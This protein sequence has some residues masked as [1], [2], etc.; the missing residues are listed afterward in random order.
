MGSM[1]IQA[2]VPL[3]DPP[4]WPFV[5]WH[6]SNPIS[7]WSGSIETRRR[8]N[9]GSCF[10]CYSGNYWTSE[11]ELIVFDRIVHHMFEPTR[12]A[13]GTKGATIWANAGTKASILA[14]GLGIHWKTSLFLLATV[15]D[16][17]Q[18]KEKKWIKLLHLRVHARSYQIINN[19]CTSSI[20]QPNKEKQLWMI[21][22]NTIK[23]ILN[24]HYHY[25]I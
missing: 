13:R 22:P 11:V 23:Q 17:I 10:W 7:I 9:D 18:W 4:S 12:N 3:R 21:K 15:S 5:E 19:V 6:P 24:Y 20:P 1:E 25:I 16:H 8:R 14:L 2:R